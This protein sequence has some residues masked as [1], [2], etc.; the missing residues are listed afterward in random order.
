[1]EGPCGPLTGTFN[2]ILSYP[3][4]IY[5]DQHHRFHESLAAAERLLVVGYS[6]RDKAINARLVAWSA[7]PGLRRMVVIHRDPIGLGTGARGAIRNK[8]IDWQR[9]G[10]LTFLPEHLSAGTSWHAIRVLLE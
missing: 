7:R 1:M 3:T 2:K 10:L 4:G 9:R 5:A 8:W 6:F